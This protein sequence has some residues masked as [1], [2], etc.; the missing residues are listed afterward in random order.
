MSLKGTIP[1]NL[2]YVRELSVKFTKNK[3]VFDLV[4]SMLVLFFSKR[5]ENLTVLHNNH[6]MKA[7]L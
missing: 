3:T 7:L 6:L 5:K 4:R 2:T 1:I